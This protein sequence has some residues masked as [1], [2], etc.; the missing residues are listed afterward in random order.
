[1]EGTD[2][3]GGN[4]GGE[5]SGPAKGEPIPNAPPSGFTVASR[6]TGVSAPGGGSDIE[7]VDYNQ[8]EVEYISNLADF[9]GLRSLDLI[10]KIAINTETGEAFLIDDTNRGD[11][12]IDGIS[13][14]SPTLQAHPKLDQLALKNLLDTILPQIRFKMRRVRDSGGSPPEYLDR[15]LS[16]RINLTPKTTAP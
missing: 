8:P 16:L 15:N 7:V 5:Q 13:P 1:V 14:T 12:V 3:T 9:E 10:L 2:P 6:I 11:K 4:P